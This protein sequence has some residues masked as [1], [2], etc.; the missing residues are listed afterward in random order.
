LGFDINAEFIIIFYGSHITIPAG[1][2]YIPPDDPD[3]CDLC[4]ECP[5]CEECEECPDADEAYDDGYADATDAAY[6][7]GY[8]DGC[9][10]CQQ[11]GNATQGSY[12][13]QDILNA[14]RQGY[15]QGYSDGANGTGYAN[16]DYSLSCIQIENG[17]DIPIACINYKDTCFTFTLEYNL[18][19][20][21][22]QIGADIEMLE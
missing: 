22:W 7:N 16:P 14:Q 11:N 6:D 10:D 9:A 19:K 13:Y 5:V 1:E 4:D 3:P 15:A 2:D 20:S 8:E 18:L 21:A 12:T 17:L